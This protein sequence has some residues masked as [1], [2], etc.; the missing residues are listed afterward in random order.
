MQ[1]SLCVLFILLKV[2]RGNKCIF[3]FD[4]RLMGGK[5]FSKIN[6]LLVTEVSK[7]NIS[8]KN[9]IFNNIIDIQVDIHRY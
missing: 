3:S 6:L 2:F 8:S 9:K 1:A 7:Q 4:V 5:P